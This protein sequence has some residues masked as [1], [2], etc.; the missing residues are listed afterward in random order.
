[1][2]KAHIC[3]SFIILLYIS[4]AGRFVR[5][6]AQSQG[7]WCVAK[8]GTTTKQLQNKLDYACSKIDCQVVSTGGTCY[9]P[10]NLYNMAS[11]AMNLYYQ[12]EGRYFGNCNFEGSGLIAI[13]DPSYGCCKYQFN[14]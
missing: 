13:T 11:V 1:M 4:S 6:N 3:L 8:P 12:A 5:V 7:D 14:K 10:D 9:S 2:A